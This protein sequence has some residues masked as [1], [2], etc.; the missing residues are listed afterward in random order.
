M[1]SMMRL[2]ADA[3]RLVS[4]L[5]VTYVDVIERLRQA[6]RITECGAYWQ[7]TAHRA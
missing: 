1:L 3:E 2:I 6:P 5:K 7:H 4:M